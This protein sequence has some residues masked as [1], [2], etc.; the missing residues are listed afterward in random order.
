MGLGGCSITPH[1]C[2]SRKGNARPDAQGDVRSSNV[3]LWR[4][5]VNGTIS[6]EWL[7]KTLPPLLKSLSLSEDPCPPPHCAL[8]P[9]LK[10]GEL[11]RRRNRKRAFRKTAARPALNLRGSEIGSARVLRWISDATC[12]LDL[13]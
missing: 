12:A 9:K 10:P 6:G 11:R 13:A 8:W 1:R 2:I 7:R 5:D 3:G 4:D